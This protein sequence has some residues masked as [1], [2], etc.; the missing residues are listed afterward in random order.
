MTSPNEGGQGNGRKD[1][2]SFFGMSFVEDLFSGLSEND[3]LGCMDCRG[4]QGALLNRRYLSEGKRSRSEY[5][6]DGK[7]RMPPKGAA[8]WSKPP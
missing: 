3:A 2:G 6:P 1:G 4:N 7:I 5:G 8:S